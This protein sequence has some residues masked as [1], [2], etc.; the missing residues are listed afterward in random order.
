MI[1]FEELYKN[2]YNKSWK[3]WKEL[4]EIMFVIEAKGSKSYK[5][6]DSKVKHAFE[7]LNN[8]LLEKEIKNLIGLE[9]IDPQSHEYLYD[10]VG[11]EVKADFIDPVRNETYDLQCRWNFDDIHTLNF[12]KADHKLIYIKKTNNLYEYDAG[13]DHCYL[14]KHIDARYIDTKNYPYEDEELG[15]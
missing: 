10:K 8:Y 2:A 13:L 11:D 1:S 4:K 14:I 15:L 6:K 12:H 5:H 7:F 3:G 9:F